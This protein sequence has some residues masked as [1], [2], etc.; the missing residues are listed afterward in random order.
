MEYIERIRCIAAENADLW[1]NG[2]KPGLCPLQSLS[3]HSIDSQDYEDMDGNI[4]HQR[5][6]CAAEQFQLENFTRR[7][8]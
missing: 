3:I 4:K 5:W 7:T 1:T 2:N 6:I 8:P